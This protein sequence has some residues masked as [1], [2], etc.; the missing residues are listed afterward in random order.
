MF[1]IMCLPT[2]DAKNTWETGRDK[3]LAPQFQEA[4]MWVSEAAMDRFASMS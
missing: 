4:A 3:S 2:F 1:E